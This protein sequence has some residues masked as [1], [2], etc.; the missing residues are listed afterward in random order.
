[1]P[2][3][4]EDVV[5]FGDGI[6]LQYSFTV[7]TKGK[8][9]VDLKGQIPMPLF[10]DP[11]CVNESELQF[12]KIFEALVVDPIKLQVQNRIRQR[13]SQLQAANEEQEIASNNA[14]EDVFMLTRKEEIQEEPEKEEVK[15]DQQQES[16][17][18]NTS[19]GREQGNTDEEH[20]DGEW[21][22]PGAVSG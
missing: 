10:F 22:A 6:Q 20:S 15:N 1:M 19:E 4:N 9:I 3:K 2:S 17:G 8:P 14:T 21:E 11:S 18:D 16:S 12:K 13:Q 7:K 5:D